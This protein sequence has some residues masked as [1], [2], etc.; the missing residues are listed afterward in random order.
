MLVLARKVNQSII[1][2][3]SI[4]IVVIDVKGDQ[5]KIGIEAPRSIK[6]YRKEVY[7]EIKKQ[8]IESIAKDINLDKLGDLLSKRNEN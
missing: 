2:N 8:N 6:I 3:D 5:I 4:E 7:E 1:I